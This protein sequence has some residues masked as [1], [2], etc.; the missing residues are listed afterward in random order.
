MARLVKRTAMAQICSFLAIYWMDYLLEG[1][2]SFYVF[3]L[4]AT[5]FLAGVF[6]LGFAWGRTIK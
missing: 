5:A 4:S 2:G 1:S 6:I 3:L